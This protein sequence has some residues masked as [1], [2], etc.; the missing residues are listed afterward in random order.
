MYA[1]SDAYLEQVEEGTGVET[2]LLVG[3]GEQR[4][5]GAAVG[6]EGGVE[7]DLQAGG[8]LV[9]ELNEGAEGVG[10]GP[11]LGEGEAVLPV[12]VLALEVAGDEVAL[13]VERAVDLEGD[14][15]RGRGLDLER[16][17]VGG[18]VPAEEI[19]RGLAEVL[20]V[21]RAPMGMMVS[22]RW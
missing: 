4:G 11:A 7:V 1:S 17:A 12:G 6:G 22:R 9:L 21:A 3:G 13:G 20:R 16:G 15:G 2:G 19:A 5:L 14:V 18:E 8:D 10:G